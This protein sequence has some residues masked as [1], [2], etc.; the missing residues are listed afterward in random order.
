MRAA[1]YASGDG[2]TRSRREQKLATSTKFR[3][4]GSPAP[5]PGRLCVD[6]GEFIDQGDGVVRGRFSGKNKGG[7]VLDTGFEH[8]AATGNGK[9]VRFG[10]RPDA[11]AAWIAGWT[12]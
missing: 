3:R 11:A 7:A 4:R 6:S 9:V 5:G 8:A 12:R 1:D 10:N 2:R